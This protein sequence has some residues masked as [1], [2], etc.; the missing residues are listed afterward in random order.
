MPKV[1]IADKMASAA[2]DIFRDYGIDVDVKTDLSPTE[3]LA[4]IPQYDGVAVRST[5]RITAD[6]INVASNLKVIGRAGI[7]VDTVDTVAA[8]QKG[9]VVM[10][11][12]FGNATTT[13]EHAIA[14]LMALA[15]QIPQ[16]NA[17][18]H[19]GKWEKSKFMGTEITGKILGVIGCGNIGTI[20]ASR[21]NGLK[22]K[23]L[24]F[25]PFLTLERAEEIGVEKCELDEILK[26]A[27]FVTLHTP[28]TDKTRN[29][30]SAEKIALMKK[31]ARLINCARGGLVDEDALAQA[32]D[33]GHLAGAA[34][35]VFVTEPAKTH[36][37][38]GNEKLICTP[39]L[40]ASTLEAQDTVALQIAEQMSD[41]L[42]SGAVSNAINMP[43]VTASEAPV[44]KP[45]IEL[46]KQLGAFVG[47]L[48]KTG[49]A[50]VEIIYDGNVAELNT[51]PITAAAIAGL[52]KPMADNVNMVNGAVVLRDKGIKLSESKRDRTGI[53]DGYILI[54][55]KTEKDIY[56]IAGTVF[57]DK[58]PR[59]IRINN[60][61]MESEFSPQMLF[62]ENDDKPGYIGSLGTILGEADINIANFHLG[63]A[64]KGTQAVALLQIDSDI[65]N[66]VVEAIIGLPQ[67]IN[68]VSIKL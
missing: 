28:L 65:P 8:T 23:V 17:S 18:T 63:R 12:P 40:G 53:Y 48:P 59:I 68:A 31:G 58:K 4:I 56:T 66:N 37:L 27:D 46:A 32:L 39:H 6:I 15:R 64:E 43:S 35:D 50:S 47:Q 30:I 9:I 14:M 36:P 41:F 60:V 33:S 5:T 29:I 55:V 2:T 11:T 42:I 62:T 51:K 52:M 16:A 3:L 7:G 45:Y 25:D 1:L 38:F 20:V 34:L 26:R 19:A 57:S 44:L 49:I 24:A 61:F 54:H 67:V 22:M 13:A 21:A 10:N